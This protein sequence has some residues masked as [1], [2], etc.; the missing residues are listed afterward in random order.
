MKTLKNKNLIRIRRELLAVRCGL[1]LALAFC[2]NSYAPIVCSGPPVPSSVA[3]SSSAISESGT[4]T[5]Q[6]IFTLGGAV[7]NDTRLTL[8]ISGTAANGSD[9]QT[10]PTQILI[11]VGTNSATLTL[12]PILDAEI[13]GAE[14]V[15]V[16]ILA[17]DNVCV[18]VGSP[19]AATISIVET[20]NSLATALDGAGLA[21]L[22]GG[23]V[24]W[25]PLYTTTHDGVDAAQSGLVFDSQESWLETS[26]NGPGT[27][28]FWW[29]VSSE[30]DF[31][32]LR[33]HMDGIL[34]Q[35]ISGEINW[36]QRSFQI[37]PGSHTL[38]WRYVKDSNSPLGQDRAWLDMVN[39][40]PASGAPLIVAQPANQI[41]WKGA[42]VTLKAVTFGA[43]PLTQQWF[44]NAT[45]VIEDATNATLVLNNIA[46][47]QAGQ[48]RLVASNTLGSATSSIATVTLTNNQPVNQVL[49]FSDSLIASP[50]EPALANLG[51]TFQ[52][53]SDEATFNAAVTLAN[54]FSTLIIVDA[55]QGTYGFSSLAGF[56]KDGGRVLIQA[57]SLAGSPTLAATF[58]VAIESRSST[59]LPLYDWGGSPLFVAL[60]SYLDF[61]EINLD[62]DAQRLHPL[63]SA[64]AVAGFTSD[65][66]TG[67]AAIVI[68]NGGRTIVN[69]FYVEGAS[70]GTDG[71]QLAQNEISFLGGT[72]SPPPP[73]ISD[74]LYSANGEFGFN[75]VG[76]VGQV[77]VI[78]ASP[79]LQTWTALQT[80]VL[81]GSPLSFTDP[82]PAVQ[83][84]R[85]YRLR[86]EP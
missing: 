23:E 32:W 66:V 4:A 21:W 58:Q 67:G 6:F 28:T 72:T 42:N 18:Y 35:Q 43:S 80:N 76:S 65:P 81:G 1:G 75:V 11:P 13:E 33:F 79:D 86:L 45:N 15:T 84:G 8:Q 61:S 48:Y 5:A 36:Q 71:I 57:Y 74:M 38:R 34:Q 44:F 53:F 70:L 20:D 62:E 10:L 56:V 60:N 83:P 40:A 78:E 37:P 25:S 82:E 9:F 12:T 73:V 49:L 24:E 26:V 68:G 17:S 19:N 55:P 30:K 64:R 27:L 2:I 14:T 22:T 3:A 52:G 59:P 31:D 29:K 41:A 16:T 50:F 51:L 77:V 85:F 69:G 39:F 46:S 63:T 47:A 7:G 54:S